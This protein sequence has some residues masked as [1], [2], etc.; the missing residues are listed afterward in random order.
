MTT[1]KK[2]ASKFKENNHQEEGI[3]VQGK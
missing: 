3:K 2:R 1:T